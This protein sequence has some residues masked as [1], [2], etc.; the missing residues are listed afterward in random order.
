MTRTRLGRPHPEGVDHPVP[1]LANRLVELARD[2]QHESQVGGTAAR[3]TSEVVDW[4]GPDTAACISMIHRRRR[5]ETI[6]ATSETVVK[7]D[8][9]QYKLEEGPCLDAIWE[10][11]Q[12]YAGDLAVDDRWPRWAPQVAQELGV[13]SMLCSRLFTRADRLGALNVY[14]PHRHAFDEETREGILAFA[15]HAA[16]AVADAHEIEHLSIAVDRRT[17][18]GTAVGLIMA[19][20]E[21]DEASAFS[22]LRR[23]SQHSNRKLYDVAADIVQSRVIPF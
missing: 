11:D 15:A 22:L 3:I 20:F 10:A 8:A 7:G 14:S 1:S 16:V 19:R 23:M 21:V 18:I 13:R 5:I 2:L 17:K 9:L 6:A 4:T 12:V